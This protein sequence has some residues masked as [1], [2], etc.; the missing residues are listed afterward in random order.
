MQRPQGINELQCLRNEK[1]V[2]PTKAVTKMDCGRQS[3]RHERR[4]H[5]EF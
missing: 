2:K 4:I 3:Q 5:V 1:E